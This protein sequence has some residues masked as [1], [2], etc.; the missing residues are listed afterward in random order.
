MSKKD[1]IE[2]MISYVLIIGVIISLALN[3][4]GLFLYYFENRLCLEIVLD[5]QSRLSL[6]SFI[7]H[8]TQINS[9]TILSA[10]ILVILFT[11]YVRVF[12]SMVYFMFKK[13]YKYIFLTFT[14]FI[15]LSILILFH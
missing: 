1:F 10:S 4:F 14:V 13:D 15:V 2:R 3:L 6:D 8:I 5:G 9:Y 7:N 11:P 12:T